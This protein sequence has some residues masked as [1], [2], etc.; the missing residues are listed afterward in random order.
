MRT[1]LIALLRAYQLLIS[2]LLGNHCRFYPSCSEYA[3]EAIERYGVWRG[4]GLAIRR[5]ARC[6]PWHPGGIDPVPE[7]SPKDR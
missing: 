6:H 3:R 5:L 1:L 2:P 7:S 4:A